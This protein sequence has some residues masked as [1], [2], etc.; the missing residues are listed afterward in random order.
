MP[1]AKDT[2]Q[3]IALILVATLGIVLM[4]ACAKMSSVS[5]D[6]ME[7]L[8]YRGLVAL[9]LLIPYML[10]THSVSV[11]KTR[12][13]RAHIYR[14][15]IGN[16]GVGCVFWAYALLPMA[17]A[18]AL[19]FAAPLFVTALSP[20]ILQERIDGYHWAAVI[21]GFGGILLIAK[22][23]RE[24]LVNPAS[25]IGLAAAFFIA[26]V[27]MAL[28]NL[29]RTDDPL[30][31]VF[32]FLLFGVVISAPYTLVFGTAPPARLIPW[33]IGI[34]VFTAVQQVAKTT[35]YRFAEASIL[36][37]YTYSAILW[38]T[39]AGWVFWKNLPTLSVV[40]GAGVVIAGNLAI[41]WRERPQ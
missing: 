39:L 6:P 30:T 15:V 12:R 14:G 31:T 27:D 5:L 17:D 1:A 2:Y 20:L 22:P 23:S 29:G 41:A 7:M 4:N 19:L 37:P 3:G 40:I 18:T 24:M 10:Y 21:V 16:L 35:A 11:F 36:S 33:I 25:L 9:T 28:R 8:F 13:I 34:G 32:Y 38:A 26:L